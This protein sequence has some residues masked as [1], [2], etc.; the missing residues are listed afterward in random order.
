MN[1]LDLDEDDSVIYRE[2]KILKSSKLNSEMEYGDKARVYV[3]PLSEKRREHQSRL[4]LI[5]RRN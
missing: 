2:L 5:I 1:L 4:I 3:R